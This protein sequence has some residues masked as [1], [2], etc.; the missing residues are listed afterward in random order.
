MTVIL[1]FRVHQIWRENL[2]KERLLGPTPRIPDSVG[3]GWG[4]R[5]CVSN[6]FPGDV[7]MLF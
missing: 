2:L 7:M 5:I 4:L 6:K 1:N 3:L